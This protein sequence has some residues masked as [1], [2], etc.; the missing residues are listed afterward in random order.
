MKLSDTTLEF[1]RAHRTDDVRDVALHA[2]RNAEVDVPVAL[3]QIAG[4]QIARTKLPDWAE[5][6]D[7]IYPPHLAMEQCSSQFTALYKADLAARLVESAASPRT[8]VDLTGGFGVDCSY[9]AHRFDR[10]IYVERQED[11]CEIAR[12]NF[13]A[14]GLDAV[15]VVNGDAEQALA[16]VG[17]V[18]LIYLDPARRDAVGARTY[19][20]EDCTP[21]VLA[22]KE[23][24]LDAAPVVMVKLSPMLDW[25][26]TV[27]QFAGAVSEVHVVSS[28]NECKELLLVLT[29]EQSDD[30]RLF[31]V[32]DEDVLECSASDIAAVPTIA[33]E[34]ASGMTLYEPNTSIMKL[35]CFGV[36]SE[37][38]SVRAIAPNSH[39]FVADTPVAGFPGREFVIDDVLS[40]ADAKRELKGLKQANITAR[41]FPLNVADLRKKLK[42]KDGGSIYLFATTDSHSAHLILRTHKPT[43]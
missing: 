21:N 37:R 16:D 4:W 18:S 5:L 9:M 11:L 41:N 34:V 2:P 24:L 19:A 39:L 28:A 30:V 36:L 15:E 17:P 42:L 3:N 29:R 7:I 43:K 20:I 25:R 1:V 22:M 38:Y 26:R 6:D 13:A 14:L 35:G 33:E 27:E 10:A 32:N 40:M 12:H 23:E 31:A 8:L